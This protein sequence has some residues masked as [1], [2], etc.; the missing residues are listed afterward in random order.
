MSTTRIFGNNPF[1][2]YLKP[3]N[4]ITVLETGVETGVK[5][6]SIVAYKKD[7]TGT[8][9]LARAD[10]SKREL[11]SVLGV[12]TDVSNGK[13]TVVTQGFIEDEPLG[14]TPTIGTGSF[15][16][17]SASKPGE[18]TDAP[19]TAL[20]TTRIAVVQKING[21][22]LV[23]GIPGI[24]NGLSYRG[25]VNI[26]AIQPVGTVSPFIG[27]T[28]SVPKNWLLCD[29]SYVSIDSYPELYRLIGSIYGP[30]EDGRFKLPDF[31][32]RTL[33]GA[34]G[35]ENLSARFIGEFGGE[36]QHQL[37]VAEM[38]SH[39]HKPAVGT[40]EGV[41]HWWGADDR[42]GE[43]NF[44]Y[45]GLPT[46]TK[47]SDGYIAPSYK[48]NTV[49][50]NSPHN[51]MPPYSVANWIIR[52]KAESE[53]ALLDI[54]VESLTNVDKTTIPIDGDMIRYDG[55]TWKFVSNK[56]ANSK[57]MQ[58]ADD[59]SEGDFVVA[60][61]DSEGTLT[62]FKTVAPSGA[63]IIIGAPNDI[64]SIA[65]FPKEHKNGAP[66]PSPL[67]IKLGSSV[68]SPSGRKGLV[69][70][71][72][73]LE[74]E[75]TKGTVSGEVNVN[76]IGYKNAANEVEDTITIP[77]YVQGDIERIKIPFYAVVAARTFTSSGQV[78]Y[79][80][81]YYLSTETGSQFKPNKLTINNLK[82]V[83]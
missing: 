77:H 23:L 1:E 71:V 49:G 13:Y 46:A 45:D 66:R 70:I 80:F 2:V 50:G 4:K 14:M 55:S 61:V 39:N 8:L 29:G 19:P 20:G 81:S 54:N 65:T 10:A 17:L 44:D 82:F 59:V 26:S 51:N 60:A 40:N 31:R 69:H 47:P 38:P 34:G 27:S 57:D 42:I 36:E 83:Y 21:G 73:T 7:N 6:G 25:Y 76:L 78:Y 58:I 74:I 9:I 30:V 33:V 53:F 64:G 72:G 32:G 79:K 35:A 43:P 24:V 18:L 52:G 41:D 28:E 48:T 16:F 62:G 68:E 67:Q 12:V 15:G 63:N 22:F 3:T 56:I 75:A 5:K 11:S 37:S